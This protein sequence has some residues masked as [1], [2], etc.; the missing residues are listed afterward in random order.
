MTIVKIENV[1]VLDPI[2]NTDSVQTVYIEDGQ[3][4]G[5]TDNVAETINGQ[6]KWLMPTM[7]DLC[8]RLREPGQQ[9]HGTLKSEGKAAVANGILHVFTPPDSKPIVQDNGALIHGLVEKAMLDGGIYLQVIGA[10]TQGLNGQQPANMAG[11]K[12]GG[13]T[14]V[15]NANAPFA[16]DDVVI[17]TLEYAAGVNMT[18][19][20]YAEEHQIAKDGC[21]HE[22]FIASRQGLPM[23]PAL[24]ETVAIAKYLLMIEATGVRAHFGLLSCGASVELIKNAKAKGLPV[25]CDVA[26]HQLHLTDQLIDGFNSLA[27]VRPPL[28]A[29]Q[30]KVLLRQGIKDGVI[31]A[32][33]THHEP[34]SSSAKMAPFAETQPGFTAFDT[35][36]PFGVQLV[37]DGLL[38]PLE[39][40][41]KVTVQPATVAQ[42]QTRWEQEVGW[43]LVDPELEW[44]ITKDSIVSNGKN[45]P[46]IGLTV[47]GKALAT[48]KA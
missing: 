3:L 28:R 1:R 47:K 7:V 14:A 37:N 15:S 31:D 25:T 24:A 13:C 40:V 35:F 32:I 9:Q 12:K 20:F 30:D 21:V 16:N 42:M 11:L 44:T 8:A 43:V 26:M 46:L 5:A 19:V 36:I 45:T 34:L 2:Q 22:G 27:H 17:R 29:E 18:V 41:K 10:Q 39:W 48:F 23:I 33:C 38:E 6:G 4:V